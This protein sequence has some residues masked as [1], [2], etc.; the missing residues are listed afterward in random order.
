MTKRRIASQCGALVL[1]VGLA[2]CGKLIPGMSPP[3][4]EAP[5]PPPPVP[6]VP[7]VNL[8][9]EATQTV[10]PND[11]NRPSPVVVRI[12]Q[13]RNNAVFLATPYDRLFEDDKGALKEELIERS[14][15]VT[16]RP[17]D[18]TTISVVMDKEVRFLGIAA[19]YRVYD[20]IQWHVAIPTPLKGDGT[21]LVDKSSVS[22]TA[23]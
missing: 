6:A 22:F 11:N 23:K 14:V 12:Y 17:G 16:L 21:V 4:A 9:L 5:P 3:K 2:A 19:F 18:R 8:T 15:A 1:L 20:G 7:P 13:L 10:N